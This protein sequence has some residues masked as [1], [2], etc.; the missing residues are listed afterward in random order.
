MKSIDNLLTSLVLSFFVICETFWVE[1]QTSATFGSIQILNI[2]CIFDAPKRV[3][4]VLSESRDI[5]IKE[6]IQHHNDRGKGTTKLI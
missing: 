2:L 5:Y 1:K 3:C 4:I 6:W